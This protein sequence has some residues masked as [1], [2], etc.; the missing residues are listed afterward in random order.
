MRPSELVRKARVGSN[1]NDNSV[2]D[3]NG[4]KL[5]GGL[6]RYNAKRTVRP[7][8]FFHSAPDAH[9][10]SVIGDFNDWSPNAHPMQRQPDG[11]WTIQ[12]P[13]HHGHHLY[14]FLV[15]GQAILDARAQ[16]VARNARNERVSMLSVS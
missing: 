1:L 14:Q 13:L 10:V 3:W 6:H 16:G 7:V 15:D 12:I 2:M 4:S 11:S 9:A 5:I 8:N